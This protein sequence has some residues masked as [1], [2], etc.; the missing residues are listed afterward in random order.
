MTVQLLSR[1]PRGTRAIAWLGVLVGLLAFWVALPP[2]KVRAPIVPVLIGVVAVALGA[3]A[4]SRGTRRL[5][6]GAVVAGVFGI[7]LGYL[8]TRSSVTHLDQVVV[9]SALIA[10]MLRYATPLAFAAMGGIFSERSG[11]VNIGLEGMM[12]SGAFFGILAADKLGA[13]WLGLLAA[14]LA[15]AFF[16]LV[17]AFFAIHLRADQ[18]VGGFAINFLALGIT[19]YLFIDIYGG[20]GTPPNISRIPDVHLDFLKGWY[21]IGPILGQLN[22]MIWLAFATVVLAWAVLFKTPTGCAGRSAS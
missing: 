11:V 7:G 9:W 19:G 18:I 12:L 6:W 21:F 16:A 8:S 10:A 20:S 5:G 22:L 4:I 17:H 3:W 2:L 15:G 13:W 1:L 14:A